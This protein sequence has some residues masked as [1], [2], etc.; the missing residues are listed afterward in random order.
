MND[1][2]QE[3]NNTNSHEPIRNSDQRIKGILGCKCP[4]CKEGD[5]FKSKA[6]NLNKFNELNQNCKTCGF[7]FMPE[8]GFYQ[9]S[10]FFTYMVGV[11]IFIVF[12]FLTYFIFNDPPL[13]VYY[14]TIFVPTFLT[15]PWNLRYS[16]VVMLY[17]FGNVED[18]K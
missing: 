3:V 12:G 15:T 2:S 14:V 10:M 8:P 18:A 7:S 13:W 5:M 4:V 16:K 17:Y 11:A 1:L 6:T 9:I